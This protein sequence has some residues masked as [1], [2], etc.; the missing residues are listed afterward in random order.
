LDALRE[1]TGQRFDLVVSDVVMPDMDGYDLYMEL[2]ERQPTLPVILMTGYLYDRDHVIKRSK[3]AGLATGVLYKKPI[4]L[5]RLKTIIRTH[6]FPK[7]GHD[8]ER[9]D[10]GRNPS[11]P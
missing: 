6:C 3:L 10:P 9:R 1:T 7:E 4:D 5:E 11:L 2:K 8:G